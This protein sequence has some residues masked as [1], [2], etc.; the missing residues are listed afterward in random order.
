M[1]ELEQSKKEYDA[2]IEFLQDFIMGANM[3]NDDENAIR[4]HRALRAFCADTNQNIFNDEFK[5]I[6]IE[7][8]LEKF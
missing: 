7:E 5:Q 6:T 3:E 1:N 2:V 4:A 8:F